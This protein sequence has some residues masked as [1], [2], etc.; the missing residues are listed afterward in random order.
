MGNQIMLD[1]LE[2][3]YMMERALLRVSKSMVGSEVFEYSD[4]FNL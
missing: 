2:N 1:A 3:L 4:K